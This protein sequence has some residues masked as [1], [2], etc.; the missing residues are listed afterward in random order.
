MPQINW[1]STTLLAI[2]DALPI[3]ILLVDEKGNIVLTN[4]K[5]Q[6]LLGIHLQ[7]F[8]VCQLKILCRAILVLIMIV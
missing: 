1:S 5:L 3:G 8:T 4:I 7:N 2:I 6:E